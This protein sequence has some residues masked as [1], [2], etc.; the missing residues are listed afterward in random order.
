MTDNRQFVLDLGHRAALGRDDFLVTPANSDAVAWIDRWPEWP[1]HAIAIFGPEGCGKTHLAHVFA[2]RAQA[3][4]LQ[5][6]ALVRDAFASLVESHAALVVE[7][8][9]AVSDPRALLHLFNAMKESGGS[10]LLTAREAPA[11]WPVA[12]P[13]LASRLASVTAVKI[14]P[15][16]EALMEAL[17]VKL[18]TD[19]QIAVDPDVVTYLV[20]RIDRSFAAARDVAA[21]ADAASL[22]GQ[23]AVTIP[24]MKQ[25]LDISG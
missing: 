17:L 18:F 12:L 15:P 22:A 4:V 9:D 21:R 14:A 2:A 16:D 20:R 7:D 5:G 8:A 25:V 10:L 3:R 23:R 13:D 1:G 11:R 6:S 24:L 19:R